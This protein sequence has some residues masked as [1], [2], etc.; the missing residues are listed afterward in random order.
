[1]NGT[2][3]TF[4]MGMDTVEAELTSAGDLSIEGSPFRK[5]LSVR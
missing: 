1:V 5:S 3:V 4:V 2:H